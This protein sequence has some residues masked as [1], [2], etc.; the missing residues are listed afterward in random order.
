MVLFEMAAAALKDHLNLSLLQISNLTRSNPESIPPTLLLLLSAAA[1]LP[2]SPPPPTEVSS[3]HFIFI[4]YY[5]IFI[6]IEA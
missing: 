3:L 4:F 6:H 5:Y 1:T 2:T